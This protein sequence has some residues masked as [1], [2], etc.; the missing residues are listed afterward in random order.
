[1]ILK[2]CYSIF[3]IFLNIFIYLKINNKTILNKNYL[4]F[5][6]L[7]ALLLVVVNSY[8]KFISNS[9]FLFLIVFSLS[10]FL[11]NYMSSFI[12]VFQKSN[13]LDEEKIQNF[14]RIIFKLIIPLFI[15]FF[16]IVT[17]WFDKS[18]K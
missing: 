16:Q 7:T 8:F 10:I 13:L 3:F 9:L 18:F 15:T 11:M 1:M 4:Y 5:F 6:I 17:I 2:I 12:G 14:K